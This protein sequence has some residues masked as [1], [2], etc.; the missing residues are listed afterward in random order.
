MLTRLNDTTIDDPRVAKTKSEIMIAI[1]AEL[2]ASSSLHWK[3]FITMGITDHTSLRIV[4]RLSICFWIPMLQEWMA[5]SLLAYYGNLLSLHILA[6]SLLP[7]IQL[8]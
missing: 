8:Y 1:E 4:R 3:Q 2:E 7:I 5:C 6:Y